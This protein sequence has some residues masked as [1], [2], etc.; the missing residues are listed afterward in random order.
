MMSISLPKK[1]ATLLFR[2]CEEGV[3]TDH[4]QIISQKVGDVIFK[5]KAG[6]YIIYICIYIFIHLYIYVYTNIH[7]DTY[8]YIYVYIY[9][10]IYSYVYI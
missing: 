10:Y 2:D 6:M 7:I 3:E 8:V 4:K 5:F 1:G 9:I